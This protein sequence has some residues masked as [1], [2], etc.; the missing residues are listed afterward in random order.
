MKKTRERS[1]NNKKEKVEVMIFRIE[2]ELKGQYL[3]YCEENGFSYGKR[4]RLLI[5][6]DLNNGK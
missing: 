4:L 1:L 5:K 3:N 2:P 6:N